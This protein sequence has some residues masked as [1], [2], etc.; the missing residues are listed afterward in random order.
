MSRADAYA[1]AAGAA[2]L[3]KQMF[4]DVSLSASGSMS[5][6]SCHDPAHGF[7]PA[8]ALP[9]QLG[10]PTMDSPGVRNVPSLTYIQVVPPYTEHFFDNEDEGDE[11]VD[12]GPTGGLTWDGRADRGSAQAQ[13]P[14]LSPFEMANTSAADVIKAVAKAP[15]ADQFKALYGAD[16]FNEPDRAFE[17]VTEALEAY[18]QSYKDFYPY[19][20]KYDAFL[21]GVAQL[22]PQEKRGLDLFE[23]ADKG[24]CSSCHLSQAGQ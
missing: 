18:E 5:C 14:L 11:S 19:S 2:A 13:I 24:N 15:Y 3:G 6:A 16:I 17:R 22:T 9:V 21:K 4:F 10:G 1:L 23:A 20:S 12:N 7:S 8:N